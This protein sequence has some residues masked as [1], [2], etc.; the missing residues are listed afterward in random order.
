MFL[1]QDIHLANTPCFTVFFI[2]FAAPLTVI[3]LAGSCGK[4]SLLI[5]SL[6]GHSKLLGHLWYKASVSIEFVAIFY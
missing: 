6:I 4:I 3:L 2:L 1:H 5:A